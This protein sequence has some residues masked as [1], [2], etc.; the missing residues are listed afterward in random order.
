VVLGICTVVAMCFSLERVSGSQ[1]IGVSQDSLPERLRITISGDIEE[2]IL[3][4]PRGRSNRDSSGYVIGDIPECIREGDLRE[5]GDEHQPM[6]MGF[7]LANP[8]RGT[9]RVA[10]HMP[11][12]SPVQITVTHYCRG[13]HVG[14]DAW[15]GTVVGRGTW[16]INVGAGGGDSCVVSVRKLL[17]SKRKARHL[18]TA[19]AGLSDEVKRRRMSVTDQASTSK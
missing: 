8:Q 1:A 2:I 4:D 5:D 3:T 18:R 10:G 19:C 15:G 14:A 9:Y 7:T 16:R 6:I 11:H 12:R 13:E 17:V